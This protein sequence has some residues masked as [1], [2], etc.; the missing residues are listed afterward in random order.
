MEACHLSGGMSHQESQIPVD[1]DR[2]DWVRSSHH[3]P[4][5]VFAARAPSPHFLIDQMGTSDPEKLVH[6]FKQSD[7]R[8]LEKLMQ[9]Q[10][11]SAEAAES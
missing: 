4:H 10:R 2:S 8:C 5:N 3:R 11:D 7:Q 9:N 1:F 6:R